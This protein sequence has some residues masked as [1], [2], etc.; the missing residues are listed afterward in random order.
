MEIALTKEEIEQFYGLAFISGSDH[1][2]NLDS[3]YFVDDLLG[4]VT[5]ACYEKSPH[6]GQAIV[7]IDS[8]L[9]LERA[10]PRLLKVFGLDPSRVDIPQF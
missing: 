10:V 9:A 2:G 8:K 5:I 6:P 1:L 3:T 4:P 7:F